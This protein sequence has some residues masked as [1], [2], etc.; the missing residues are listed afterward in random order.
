MAYQ[1]YPGSGAQLSIGGVTADV[2]DMEM[3][4]QRKE[5]ETTTTTDL[6]RTYMAGRYGGTLTVTLAQNGDASS[7]TRSV[8]A[9]F[10]GQSALGAEVAFVLTDGGVGGGGVAQ[11]YNFDGIIQNAVHSVRQDEIDTVR[12]EIV[13]TSTITGA[14]PPPS[15]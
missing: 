15:P 3:T 9:D 7:A 5:V 4:L 8:V 2:I 12:L 1:P 13:V 10:L 14:A 6:Y 11:V